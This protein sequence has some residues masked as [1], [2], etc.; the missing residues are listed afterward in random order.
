MKVDI[1]DSSPERAELN[2]LNSCTNLVPH[3]D[4][5]L[6][7]NELPDNR[8]VFSIQP[9][10]GLFAFLSIHMYGVRLDEFKSRTS[11]NPLYFFSISSNPHETEITEQALKEMQS[12]VPYIG[13]D[14]SRQLSFALICAIFDD[15]W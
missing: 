13:A 4:N 15:A 9:T 6:I 2:N 8:I 5:P 7:L 1:L 3:R 14:L 11:Q 10:Q 12:Q